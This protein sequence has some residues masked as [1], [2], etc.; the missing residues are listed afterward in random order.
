MDE[1]IF[2]CLGLRVALYRILAFS[3]LLWYWIYIFRM[4]PSCIMASLYYDCAHNLTPCLSY[5]LWARFSSTEGN[6]L[7]K[8]LCRYL[9]PV[10]WNLAHEFYKTPTVYFLYHYLGLR[11]VFLLE[12]WA[13]DRSLSVIERLLR[14]WIDLSDLTLRSGDGLELSDA[15]RSVLL[16]LR[17]RFDFLTLFIWFLMA[18]FDKGS[19]FLRFPK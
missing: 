16:L 11:S 14:L 3:I 8:S 15:S 10:L 17:S 18:D 4:D 1:G 13:G 6:T 7:P 2:F 9:V 5:N 19:C 12:R